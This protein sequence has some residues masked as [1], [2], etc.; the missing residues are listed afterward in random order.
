MKVPRPLNAARPA[1]G[2]RVGYHPAQFVEPLLL[3]LPGRDRTL[4]DLRQIREDAGLRAVLRL[5]VV[6]V[7]LPRAIGYAAWGSRMAERAEPSS[8]SSRSGG[9]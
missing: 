8:S 2:S 7:P 6:P 1:P 4:E 5:P 9:R 3:L